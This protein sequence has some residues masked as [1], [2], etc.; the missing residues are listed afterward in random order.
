MAGVALGVSLQ[1]DGGCARV[2]APLLRSG[3]LEAVE[4]T[5][6]AALPRGFSALPAWMQ[7][8]LRAFS[9]T[10]RL[11]AHGVGLSGMS[12]GP[13]T[14]RQRAWIDAVG[15]LVE[16][17]PCRRLSVHAGWSTAGDVVF[18]APLAPPPSSTVAWQSLADRLE[19]LRQR[20]GGPVGVENL[21]F[22]WSARDAWT[23][24]PRWS[25]L[26]ASPA[27]PYLH[28][29][30]HNLWCQAATW[31]L[32]PVTLLERLPLEAARVIHV[33]GGRWS[34]PLPHAPPVRRDTHD[35][36]VPEAVWTLLVAALDR[37]PGVE[38][39]FYERV[40]GAWTDP[41]GIAA[42]LVDLRARLDGWSRR[43]PA[44]SPPT[45]APARCPLSDDTSDTLAAWQAA[46][47]GCDDGPSL[48][49]VLAADGPYGRDFDDLDPRM[50]HVAAELIGR[51]TRRA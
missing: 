46:V 40:P 8:V 1:P 21:G 50:A 36:P 10:G 16:T 27:G 32:D 47:L 3:A 12:G 5:V 43:A 28:L 25:A 26:V 38:V 45:S 49:R 4:W 15:T 22:G 44:P 17:L 37:A 19:A 23:R 11:W 24:G 13:T 31:S 18:G 42:E 7:R 51:W 35:G 34:Q 30:L 33:A 41:A 6:D 29:D 20:V 9:D 39:V 14:G 2:V 48:C